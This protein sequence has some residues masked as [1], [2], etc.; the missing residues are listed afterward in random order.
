MGETPGP[1][2]AVPAEDGPMGQGTKSFA[3]ARLWDGRVVETGGTVLAT[4]TALDVSSRCHRDEGIAGVGRWRRRVMVA[5]LAGRL[6]AGRVRR[7]VVPMRGGCS[8]R[9]G[10]P[11][12]GGAVVRGRRFAD[13][14]RRTAGPGE[15]AWWREFARSRGGLRSPGGL[16]L[17]LEVDGRWAG[18]FRLFDLDMFDRNAR[19]HAWAD[20]ARADIGVRTA[21]TRVV[22]EHAFHTLGLY[23]V[24]TEIDA[25]DTE[26]AA[27]AACAGLREEGI[28]RNHHG[29]TGRR[30]D[31]ALWASTVAF[32]GRP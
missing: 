3:A 12:Y 28:M 18:E 13:G 11:G 17:V 14:G 15:G 9:L 24:A 1:S 26:S 29:P 22:L 2:A 23:R 27:V 21:A 32:P 10:V 16:V 20:S 4:R 5:Y 25:A 6:V 7:R 30:A 8:V 31:H 19:L